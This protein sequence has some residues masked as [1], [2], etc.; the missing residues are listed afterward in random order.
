[1]KKLKVLSRKSNLAL[2]QVN[3]L[4]NKTDI[5]WELITLDSYGDK[6]RDISLMENPIKDIFTKELDTAILNDDGDIAIHSAKDLPYPLHP[7]LEIIALIPP[8]D[9]TDSLVSRDNIKLKDLPKGSKI[10]TSS[11]QR[12]KQILDRN[13]DLEIFS[14]RGTIEQRIE[15]VDN[16]VVDSLIVATC[17]LKRL[18]LENRIAEVLD[19][20]THPLQG[21]LA[22]TSKRNNLSVRNIFSELDVLKNYGEVDLIGFGP[23]NPDLLTIKADNKLKNADI[24]FYD[25]LIP[26]DFLDNYPGKKVYVGKRKDCH[27]F[28]QEEICK[29]L[30][31]AARDGNKVVRLKG[32]DPFIFGRGGEES[33]YLESRLINV[34]TTPGITAAQGAASSINVPLTKRGVSRELS[35]YTAHKG[36]LDSTSK[37]HVFYMGGTKLSDI[38]EKLLKM[39]ESEDTPILLIENATLDNQ[40]EIKTT[41]KNMHNEKPNLP[42]IIIS[43]GVSTNYFPKKYILN[44]GL[45]AKDYGLK[46]KVLHYPLISIKKLEIDVDINLYNTVIFTSI[47]A[48]KHFTKSIDI[49]GKKIISI[50]SGTTRALK[51]LDIVVDYESTKP[52]SDTLY[53]ELLDKNF[54][55]ILYP[56]SM[57]SD[58]ELQTLKDLESLPIYTTEQLELEDKIDLNRVESIIFTSPSTV[59]SFVLNFK[60]IP[61]VDIFCFGKF[62]ESRIN[63][64]KEGLNVQTISL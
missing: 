53:N 43:G 21:Y 39:G 60:E 28:N 7:D 5:E 23:G 25:A 44:T 4:L 45:R 19:F 58:N 27:S 42:V 57:K 59:D 29:K 51:K 34:I 37:T 12:Q 56:C 3:E 13:P 24:I 63:Y 46:G 2:I 11:P 17:A 47:T 49:T 22:V 30:Y 8:F 32:G 41:I 9:Q 15:Q 14:I 40:F 48:V 33:D 55:K 18:G 64:Y 1:M 61:N 62:T 38:Q 16:G 26:E 36:E 50:G 54:T 35:L 6:N 52:D 20:D 31:F 10:G